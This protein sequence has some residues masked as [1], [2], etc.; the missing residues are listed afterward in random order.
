MILSVISWRR[1]N[2]ARTWRETVFEAKS[3]LLSQVKWLSWFPSSLPYYPLNKIK[4]LFA[5]FR[6]SQMNFPNPTI[7]TNQHPP[8]PQD[9][10]RRLTTPHIPSLHVPR[11]PAHRPSIS[12]VLEVTKFEPWRARTSQ[13]DSTKDGGRLALIFLDFQ[14]NATINGWDGLLCWRRPDFLGSS[15]YTFEFCN[16]SFRLW[17]V[18]NRKPSRP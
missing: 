10:R 15:A 11:I 17:P 6:H 4:R 12:V 2:I 14:I 18:T 13:R 16:F 3:W 9:P 5:C 8:V 7:L 1:R